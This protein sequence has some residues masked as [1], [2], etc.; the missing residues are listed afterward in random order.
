M[1]EANHEIV[2]TWLNDAYNVENALVHVLDRHAKEAK[3][4]PDMEAKLAEHLAQ[5]RRH[6]ELVAGR[7]TALGGAPSTHKDRWSGV[8]TPLE[9]LFA[10]SADEESLLKNSISD[11]ASEN[12]EIATYRAIITAA[13]DTGD[14]DTVQVCQQILGD[15]QAMARFLDER[16]PAFVDH[17]IGQAIAASS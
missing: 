5:T 12:F 15:E 14:T 16:M 13:Q 4:F 11:Y 1:A 3:G 2:L 8:L 10:G 17:I 6:A 9:N 7:I